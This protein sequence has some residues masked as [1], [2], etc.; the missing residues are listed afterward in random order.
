MKTRVFAMVLLLALAAAACGAGDDRAADVTTSSVS[1]QTAEPVEDGEELS[2]DPEEATLPDNTVPGRFDPATQPVEDE[3]FVTGEV[4]AEII[5]MVMADAVSGSDGA[6]FEVIVSEA[7]VWNDGSLGCP[8]P[9]VFY[10]QALVDGY[11]VILAGDED[12][13]DY[14]VGQNGYFFRCEQTGTTPAGIGTIGGGDSGE[15]SG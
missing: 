5:D 2:V 13:I 7:V 9:G 15:P 3:S 10:T 6:S 4:P 8:E 1:D 11:H 12:Q 14:R